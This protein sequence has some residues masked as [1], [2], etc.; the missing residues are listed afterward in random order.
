ME[1]A[2][3]IPTPIIM[4]NHLDL[5]SGELYMRGSYIYCGYDVWCRS[6]NVCTFDSK[7]EWRIFSGVS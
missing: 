1:L 4:H 7:N 3:N 6:G 5:V 2:L